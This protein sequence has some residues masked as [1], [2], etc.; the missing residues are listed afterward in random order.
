MRRVRDMD[1]KI[2]AALPYIR[3]TPRPSIDGR[4]VNNRDTYHKEYMIG[5]MRWGENREN[6]MQANREAMAW[7]ARRHQI[8]TLLTSIK[9][10]P[11]QTYRI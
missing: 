1:C 2:V 9:F 7:R 11:C 4:Y 5:S 10:I 6:E 8:H 3:T